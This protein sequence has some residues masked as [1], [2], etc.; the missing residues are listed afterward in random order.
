MNKQV[1]ERF[2]NV[3]TNFTYEPSNQS[4][5]IKNDNDFKQYCSN[6][7][8]VNELEKI[9][10]GFLYLLDGFFKNSSVFESVAKSNID[11]VEYILIWLSYILSL[12]KNEGS[13]SLNYFYTTNINNDKY[14]NIIGGVDAYS[15][16]KDLIDKKKDFL[17][18]KFEDVSKFYDAFKLLCEMYIEFDD[19]NKNCKKYF[20]GDNKFFKK[21]EELKNDPS[22]SRNN[23]YNQILSTL[24]NDYDNL[25]SKCNNF[26]SHLTYSLISIAFIFIAITIFWRFSYKYSLFGFRKRA[27]KQYLREKIK[28]IKKRMNH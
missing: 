1:C 9:D 19:E 21:Y 2:K 13:E 4:Y 25:K 26:P 20:E 17:N 28:N 15:S 5:Q 10:A 16:Y 18:I 24:L 6:Q 22:I 3:W 12:K 7:N 11:L 27:Q 23:S 14:T 8:C